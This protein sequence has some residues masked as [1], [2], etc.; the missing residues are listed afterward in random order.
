MEIM[1]I[2]MIAVIIIVFAAFVFFMKRVFNREVVSAT[3]HLDNLRE[4]Y[5]K[6][7]EEIQ[8]QLEEVK[9]QSQELLS[10]AAKD[11]QQQSESVIKQAQEEQER[12]IADAHTKAEEV[13]RQADNARLALLNDIDQKINERAIEKS[14]ELLQIALPESFRRQI[15]MQWVD[16]LTRSGFDALDRLRIPEDERQVTVVS[17]FLLTVDQKQNLRLKLKEKLGSDVDIREET[18]PGVI[19]GVV[20]SIGSLFFDGSLKFKIQEAARVQQSGS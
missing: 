12:V 20:V 10:N 18:D 19:A 3:S 8:K 13:I 7:E 11:A 14:V 15:H 5:A 9:R 16:D 6:K 1:I 4:E 17:A 2:S